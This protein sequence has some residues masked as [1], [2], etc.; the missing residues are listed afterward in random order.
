MLISDHNL[1][2]SVLAAERIVGIRSFHEFSAVLN[3]TIICR[4]VSTSVDSKTFVFRLN[5]NFCPLI[6]HVLDLQD[7]NRG[8]LLIIE[9]DDVL[10]LAQIN[11]ADLETFQI[12]ISIFSPSL[13]A[14]KFSTSKSA[15]ITI[16]TTHVIGR[17]T[18]PPTKTK[19]NSIVLSDEQFALIQDICDEF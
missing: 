16:P 6:L 13:P 17:L 5:S 12:T 7:F 10:H 2:Y 8:A 9:Q 4:S 1:L 11:A 18:N 19:T 3:G 14:K 15:P